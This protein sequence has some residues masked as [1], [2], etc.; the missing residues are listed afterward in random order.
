M[1]SFDAQFYTLG[2]YYRG[3]TRRIIWVAKELEKNCAGHAESDTGIEG[4]PGKAHKR[5]PWQYTYR[6]DKDYGAFYLLLWDELMWHN[7][8]CYARTLC[9][10]IVCVQAEQSFGTNLQPSVTSCHIL[11][12]QKEIKYKNFPSV[13]VILSQMICYCL[14]M[15]SLHL[16]LIRDRF[17][18]P[19]ASRAFCGA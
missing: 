19:L 5:S 7:Q 9:L 12:S 17:F 16:D 18:Y 13:E 3:H 14:T 2:D 4:P 10:P 15:S 11:R 8:L 6:P 1:Q